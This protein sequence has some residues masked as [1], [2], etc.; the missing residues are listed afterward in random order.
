MKSACLCSTWGSHYFVQGQRVRIIVTGGVEFEGI[1]SHLTNFTCHLRMVQPKKGSSESNGV[2]KREYPTMSFQKKDI[3]DARVMGGNS[4]KADVKQNG[5]SCRQGKV[6][7]RR[8]N[9]EAQVRRS[10]LRITS[11]LIVP[12]PSTLR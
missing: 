7:L 9:G 10:A 4:G 3:S 2:N 11:G 1:F 6:V 8:A 5:K 12:S